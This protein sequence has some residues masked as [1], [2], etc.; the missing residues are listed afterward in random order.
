MK[1]VRMCV[2]V[3]LAMS[4]P[5]AVAAQGRQSG[6]GD[7]DRTRELER[8]VVATR[9]AFTTEVLAGPVVA[10]AP[11]S[12]DATTTVTQ[13]LGDG[14]RIEQTT[15]ARFYRDRAGRVRREQTILGLGALNGGGNMQ[16]IT[17]APD[18]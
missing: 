13:V 11:F 3:C 6:S 16:T 4:L 5:A 2:W 12:A 17:I 8:F 15:T 7:P 18:P 10:D 1:S 9:S 14:T